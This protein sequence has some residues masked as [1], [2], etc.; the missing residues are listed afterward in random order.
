MRSIAL[1]L[2]SAIIG[3]STSTFSLST[4]STPAGACNNSPELCS[5]PYN[6]VVHLGAHDSPFVRDAATDESVSGNQFYNATVALSAGV[7]LLTGQ[8]H[9][10]NGGWHLCHS[11]CD[12]LDA[13]PLSEWLAPISEW[14]DYN[15]NDVVT[16]LLVNSDNA[17]AADLDAQFTLSGI[18][19]YAYS[20]PSTTTPPATWPS[21]E[22]FISTNQR[23]LTFVAS[24]EPA[25]NTDPSTAYLMDEFTFIFENPFNN[26][27][28]QAFTCAPNR[29]SSVENDIPAALSSNRMALMNHFLDQNIGILNIEIPDVT[30]ITMTNSPS[31]SLVGALGYS[32][33][34]C[35]TAYDDRP[36]TYLLV[37]FFDQGPAIA[38]VDVLNGV[39]NPVGRT[40]PPARSTGAESHSEQSFAGVRALVA[41][42]KMGMNPSLGAWIW[43]AGQWSWGGLNVDGGDLV[44]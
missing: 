40:P 33:E 18:K 16:V 38:T 25:S 39:T 42:V 28:P 41:Q 19:K 34:Q 17:N 8:V 32:A 37:D 12:L 6:S 35:K 22:S 26:L 30:N 27:S 29:P 13:G 24:L 2:L 20:P 7:R 14:L 10:S 23:L 1:S 11:S 5:R 43:A 4:R 15:P 9:Q 44:S 31:T 36:P 3:L 21:L